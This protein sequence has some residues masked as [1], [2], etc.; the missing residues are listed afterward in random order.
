MKRSR[1]SEEQIIGILNEHHA[2]MS[3]ADLCRKHGV[4]DATFYKW[5]TSIWNSRNR[6]YKGCTVT[7]FLSPFSCHRFPDL[8]GIAEVRPE[9]VRP[10][11]VRPAE[12]WYYV[13]ILATPFVPGFNA[14]L[15]LCEMFFIGHSTSIDSRYR[16]GQWWVDFKAGCRAPGR[17]VS[18]SWDYLREKPPQYAA[19]FRHRQI[20]PAARFSST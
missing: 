17:L 7:V 1:F 10:A 2:G 19:E 13:R 9:V 16:N 8:I 6:F 20:N 4:S 14:F 5:R 11:E 12:I 15:K 3:A 18:G